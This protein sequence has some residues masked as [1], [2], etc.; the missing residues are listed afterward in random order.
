MA[1]MAHFKHWLPIGALLAAAAGFVALG[2]WQLDRA[3]VNRASVDA[4]GLAAAQPEIERPVSAREAE[5]L[6]HRRIRLRGRYLGGTQ[7]LLDNMTYR[8]GAVRVDAAGG[9]Q[10]RRPRPDAG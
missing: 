4:Y 7:I 3:D 6:R 5:T 8:A 2:R 9:R 10:R 1:R